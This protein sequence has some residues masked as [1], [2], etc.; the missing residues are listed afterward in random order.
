VFPRPSNI[1][2]YIHRIGRTG[3]AG[4]TG[5]AISFF[6][7]K[8]NKLAKELVEI[9]REAQQV[10][11]PELAAMAPQGHYGGGHSR[12]G[13]SGGGGGRGGFGG[14]SRFSSAGSFGNRY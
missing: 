10:I 7:E 4:A 3:R 6:T 2:D 5:L 11:P 14:G 1:E 13:P 12:Y 8:H 9:L